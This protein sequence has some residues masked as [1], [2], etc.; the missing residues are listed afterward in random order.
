L[1]KYSEDPKERSAE[2]KCEEDIQ[3]YGLHVL[4]VA[5]GNDWPEFAYSVGL[6][7]SYDHPEVIVLGL[8]SDVAHHILNALADVIRSGK[9]FGPED[10]TEDLLEGYSCKFL[11]VPFEQMFAHFGWA[12]WYYDGRAFPVLQLV[13]PDRSGRWPWAPGVSPGFLSQQ[14][15]LSTISVPK[16]AKR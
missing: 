14:P 9:R 11:A 6:F 7:E 5:G 12:I 3:R 16:W 13:Y 1:R 2:E 10:E 15:V 4:K 8:P